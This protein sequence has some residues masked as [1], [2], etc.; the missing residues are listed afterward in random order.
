ML[1]QF[2]VCDLYFTDLCAFKLFINIVIIREN[3]II[4]I[5]KALSPSLLF[6]LMS[7]TTIAASLSYEQMSKYVNF[8]YKFSYI[9]SV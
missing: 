9:R 7:V 2:W 3:I 8:I 6:N 1:F 4:D 5:R